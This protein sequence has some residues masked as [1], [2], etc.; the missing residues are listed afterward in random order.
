MTARLAGVA[1][2]FA[3]LTGV[4]VAHADLGAD[5]ARLARAWKAHGPVHRLRPRLAER[6]KP[7]LVFLPSDLSDSA[8]A[9]CASIAVLGPPSTHFTVRT[10]GGTLRSAGPDNLPQPSL[11]GLVELRRCGVRRARLSTLVIEMRSPRAVL[12]IIAVRS[13]TAIR[14]AIEVLPQRNP[15]PIARF[16]GW[17]SKPVPMPLLAR[18]EAARARAR[19]EGGTELQETSVKSSLGGTGALRHE[20]PPGCHRFDLLVDGSDPSYEL[21]LNPELDARA[22]LVS[23][24][25]GDGLDAALS[26]CAGEPTTVEVDFVGAPSA[27]PIR[28]LTSRWPL[29][30][31]LPMNWGP[32]GRARVAAVLKRH[33]ARFAGPLVDQALGVQGPTWMP[34]AVE[35]G[36]C[37]LG[38]LVAVRG[39][40]QTLALAALSGSVHSQNHARPGAEGTL[41]SFCARSERSVVFEAD[42][43]GSDL[44]WLFALFESGRTPV[45]EPRL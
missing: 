10:V 19:R 38:V 23:L 43:R 24:E 35:P 4:V 11:A 5:S 41:V 14:S 44:F 20:V 42:S 29:P 31:G 27:A 8:A 17:S 9:F 2:A 1:F 16:G 30:P 40:A 45:G 21:A 3:I 33:D 12:E 37:Y 26:V 25:H 6:T 34:I 39:S 28:V 18:L 15:G 22:S 13:R 32:T 7:M 36:S